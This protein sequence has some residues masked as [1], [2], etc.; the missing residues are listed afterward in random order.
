M[1]PSL[2]FLVFAY[3]ICF[4]FQNKVPFLY[5]LPLL[6]RMLPCTYCTGTHAGWIAWLMSWAVN[7]ETPAHGWFIIPS[8]I[9]WALSAAAF[10]YAVDAGIKWLEVNSATLVEDEKDE[11]DVE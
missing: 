6:D 2:G 4:G 1:L 7:G 9:L 10:C 8:I 11:E 5:K 3:G